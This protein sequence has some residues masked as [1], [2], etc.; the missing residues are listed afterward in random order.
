MLYSAVLSTTRESTTQLSSHLPSQLLWYP[1]RLYYDAMIVCTEKNVLEAPQL[2]V[3]LIACTWRA[4]IRGETP[5][6]AYSIPEPLL[7][8]MSLKVWGLAS[9]FVT[10]WARPCHNNRILT[11]GHIYV[12]KVD[13]ARE[14]SLLLKYSVLSEFTVQI[15]TFS[16]FRFQFSKNWSRKR[17]E[18]IDGTKA[19]Q[20]HSIRTFSIA[21]LHMF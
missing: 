14:I 12:W 9:G 8:R 21:P 15:S 16:V 5:K 1:R 2:C 13:E 20:A 3:W 7:P 18:E 4:T 19:K 11:V 17:R 6:T 10:P